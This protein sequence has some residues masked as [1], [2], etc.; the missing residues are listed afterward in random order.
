MKRNKRLKR[1]ASMISASIIVVL[2]VLFAQQENDVYI[3]AKKIYTSDNGRVVAN[4][5]ILIKD[6][7]IVKVEERARPPKKARVVDFSDSV[8]MQA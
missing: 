6:G 5:G 4:G 2:S 8:I 3:M 1:K 7:K